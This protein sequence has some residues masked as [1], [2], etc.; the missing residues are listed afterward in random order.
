MKNKICCVKISV[1]K[2]KRRLHKIKEY[3]TVK[4]SASVEYT[5]KKSVFISNIKAVKDKEEADAFIRSIKD[6]YPDATHNVFAYTLLFSEISKISDD[7]EPKGTAG[8]PIL[9]VIK[10]EGLCGVCIVVTRY[11]GGI[12]L[13]AGGLVRAY[14]KA[15]KLAVD[16]AGTSV[17]SHFY[18]FS[19]K[20]K[21]SDY[22][23]I[24][25]ELAFYGVK[26]DKEEFCDM[27]IMYLA[28]R[29]DKY[30]GFLAF[31]NDF[32]NGSAVFTKTGE[33]YDVM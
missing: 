4:E 28:A 20:V 2:E 15:A 13:G 22:E 27:V 5:E 33:R 31:V 14:A 3:R 10:H 9:E 6:K 24:S 30:D 1:N 29:T 18:E 25:K 16:K 11:F 17:Y 23:K 7:G 26:C 8:A 21:Y 19:L 32:T 12:L